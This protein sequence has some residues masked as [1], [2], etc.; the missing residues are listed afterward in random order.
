M[1][2]RYSDNISATIVTSSK[3]AAAVGGRIVPVSAEMEQVVAEMRE[4]GLMRSHIPGDNVNVC[5]KWKR[6]LYKDGY[7]ALALHV[8]DYTRLRVLEMRNALQACGA[9]EFAYQ[10]DAVFYKG[11]Y[12]EHTARA[13][14]PEL[15]GALQPASANVAANCNSKA[16][17]PGTAKF[18]P[19]H[20]DSGA[21]AFS[22]MQLKKSRDALPPDLRII[23]H[24]L[25][26]QSK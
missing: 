12:L 21:R 19:A 13:R 10:C 26:P 7:Y 16:P 25:C 8:L 4:G 9:T 17:V 1:Q 6:S 14:Y 18:K 5:M 24:L 15:F 2:Q 20:N 23:K 22:A 11:P 3:E